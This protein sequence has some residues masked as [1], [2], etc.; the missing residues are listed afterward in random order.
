M[1]K[2][3]V[4]TLLVCL[5]SCSSNLYTALLGA[6]QTALKWFSLPHPSHI[7]PYAGHL[8]GRCMHPQYLHVSFFLISFLVCSASSTCVLKG[9]LL[10]CHH[11]DLFTHNF[12][13]L[14]YDLK[15]TVYF[16]VHVLII[17][18]TDELLFYLSI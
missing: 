3:S 10:L 5:F 14:A 15:L 4:F 2:W 12:I 18:A 16:S 8:W 13:C 6:L 17:N 7:L 1:N 11:K 9:F